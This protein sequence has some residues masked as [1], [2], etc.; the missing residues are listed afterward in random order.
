MEKHIFAGHAQLPGGSDVHEEYKFLSVHMVVD[1]ELG[2]IHDSTISVYNKMH[3]EFVAEIFKDK[4]LEYD[5]DKILMQ[6]ERTVHT[7]TRRA[8]ITAI[9][10]LHNRYSDVRKKY[11]S[12]QAR[13]SPSLAQKRT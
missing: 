7:P 5:L 12:D 3:S 1:I 4:S 13:P 10:V 11:L 9:Q 8:L 6:I 2:I